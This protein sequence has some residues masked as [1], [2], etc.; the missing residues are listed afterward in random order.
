MLGTLQSYP[1]SE[2]IVN[3]AFNFLKEAA[4]NEGLRDS[5]IDNNGVD[6]IM[7]VMNANPLNE[8]I[9]NKAGDLLKI[10]GGEG[11][12]HDIKD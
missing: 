1:R 10:L 8:P 7:G 12:L 4:K 2:P 3:D 6:A 11:T 5:I 9:K